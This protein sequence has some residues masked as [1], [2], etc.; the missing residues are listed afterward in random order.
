MDKDDLKRYI[1]RGLEILRM[2]AVSPEHV[3]KVF[4]APEH[5]LMYFPWPGMPA[6]SDPITDFKAWIKENGWVLIN[7]SDY[8]YFRIRKR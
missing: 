7:D 4:D 6:P 5:D 1:E 2:V 8:Q 3:L